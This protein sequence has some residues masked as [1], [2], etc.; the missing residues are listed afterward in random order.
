[1][2]QLTEQ[3]GH[4]GC[5]KHLAG[6]WRPSLATPI[7]D[8][9]WAFSPGSDILLW[10]CRADSGMTPP[11]VAHLWLAAAHVVAQRGLLQATD[12]T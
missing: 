12:L 2:L 6:S 9:L 11:A 1:M 10:E 4:A 8:C 3:H 7:L 5:S